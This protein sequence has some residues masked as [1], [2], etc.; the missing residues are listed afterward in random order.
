MD[1]SII[2]VFN[3]IPWNVQS[4]NAKGPFT[5]HRVSTLGAAVFVSRR[6]SFSLPSFLRFKCYT[7][8][9]QRRLRMNVMLDYYR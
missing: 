2:T 3:I 8:V 6:R 7:L 4:L 1:I 5:N 9:R